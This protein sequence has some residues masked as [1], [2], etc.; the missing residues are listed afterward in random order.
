VARNEMSVSSRE[1]VTSLLREKRAAIRARYS[2]LKALPPPRPKLPL[3]LPEMLPSTAIVIGRDQF[4]AP[5][6][7]PEDVRLRHEHVIG[8][9]G[10]GKSNLYIQEKNPRGHPP[11]TGRVPSRSG[12]Q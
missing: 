8:V 4:G 2:V 9:T 11:G 5:F 1:K 6:E 7:L 3:V 10:G 12:R